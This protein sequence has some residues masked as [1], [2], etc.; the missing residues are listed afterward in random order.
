MHHS[1]VSRQADSFLNRILDILQ[2]LDDIN[3]IMKQRGGCLYK[4]TEKAA[5]QESEEE[6]GGVFL[7]KIGEAQHIYRKQVSDYREQR[8]EVSKRLKDVRSRMEKSPDDRERLESEAAS[9]E[10]TLDS[11]D[12]KQDEYEKYLEQLSEKYCAYWNTAVAEQQADAM[13]EYAAD[14]GKIMEVARRIMK[15][16][17]VPASD[18]KKL[19]EFSNEMYQTAK[20]VGAMIRRQKREKYD[21]LWGE[22]EEKEYEDPQEAAENAQ[23]PGGA[24]EVVDVGDRMLSAGEESMQ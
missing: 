8:A 10:L 21:T 3:Y 4:D 20:S 24:P 7:M 14:M 16:A 6:K 11:L 12:E 17:I 2:D 19:M 9:L 15:G 1:V 5:E 18:E 13:E 23:A 22:E